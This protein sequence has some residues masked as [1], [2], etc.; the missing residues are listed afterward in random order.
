MYKRIDPHDRKSI[1]KYHEDEKRLIREHEGKENITERYL[2]KE[3]NADILSELSAL[4]SPFHE[5]GIRPVL[6]TIRME[7]VDASKSFAK[8]I[9]KKMHQIG[10]DVQEHVLS[11]D[12]EEAD[13]VALIQKLSKEAGVH[14][15]LLME[16]LSAEWDMSHLR[17][18]IAPEKDVDGTTAQ[19]LGKL[20]AGEPTFVH[21][22]PAA[23]MALLDHYGIDLRGKQVCVIGSGML[24]GRPLSLLLSSRM[25][26]VVLCNVATKDVA[27]LARQ[28]DIIVS[29]AGVADLVDETYVREGQIVIDVGVSMKEGKLTGDVNL[30]R[31]APIVRAATPTPGGIGA[32]TTTML[33]RQL[34]EAFLGQRRTQ[35]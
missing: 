31:I 11:S 30:E 9:E 5:K 22:A 8:G 2:A 27:H 28:A 12:A 34:V 15:I 32:I 19:S 18:A 13:A 25:A 23:V 26:T 14:G 10:I 17:E 35:R 20:V 21:T 7:N 24:V 6:A 1:L 4:L 3:V 16:P 33:A 29:A